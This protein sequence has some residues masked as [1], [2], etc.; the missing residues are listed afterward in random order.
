MKLLDELRLNGMWE[1]RDEILSYPLAG[2]RQFS[3]GDGGWI[4]GPVAKPYRGWME[5]IGL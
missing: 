5:R 4:P 2:A 3:E 1:L